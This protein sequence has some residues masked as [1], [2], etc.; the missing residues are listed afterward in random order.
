M[1]QTYELAGVMTALSSLIHS[2]G[3]T[4]GIT[5]KLRREKFVQPSGSVE[6]VPVISGNS[7]RGRLRDLGTRSPPSRTV[8]AEIGL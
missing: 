6:E 2:G 4:Y 7:I 1:A 3:E 8:G 5:T